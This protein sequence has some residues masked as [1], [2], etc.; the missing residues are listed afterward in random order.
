MNAKHWIKQLEMEAHPEGGYFKQSLKSDHIFSPA[1]HPDERSLYTSIYFLLQSEDVSHFH[2]LLSDE[3]WYFHAGSSLTIHIIDESGNYRQE[4]LGLNI[5][6]GE[7]P[8]VC[9][10]KGSIFG[11]TVDEKEAYSLVGCMV[12]PGFEFADFKLFSQNDLLADF[13]QHEEV[14]SRLAYKKLT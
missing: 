8:Q 4:K 1:T 9:V 6:N 10:K 5:Q 2:Q 11:S 13:P 3:V 7:K 12:S 14:I